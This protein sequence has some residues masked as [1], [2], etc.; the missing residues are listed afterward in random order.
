MRHTLFVTM[1]LLAACA[2]TPD[3]ESSRIPNA[4]LISI[5]Q[6]LYFGTPAGKPVRL[7]P[8]VF[9]VDTEENALVLT[10]ADDKR[11]I[12]AASS[13][14]TNELRTHPQA[15]LL[16]G[17]SGQQE[18]VLLL[19]NGAGMVAVGSTTATAP[20][21]LRRFSWSKMA[22]R[23]PKTYRKPVV[24]MAAQTPPTVAAALA[25]PVQLVKSWCAGLWFEDRPGAIPLTRA[26]SENQIRWDNARNAYVVTLRK[27]LMRSRIE[28][29]AL[30]FESDNTLYPSDEYRWDHNGQY[31]S[32]QDKRYFLSVSPRSG[33]VYE[34][35]S[36]G[37]KDGDDMKATFL[38]C[39]TSI[40]KTMTYG[41]VKGDPGP[42]LEITVRQ[43]V[44]GA[45]GFMTWKTVETFKIFVEGGMS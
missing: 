16:A 43:R 7:D 3:P 30:R 26:W 11:Q 39:H 42:E 4:A 33:W 15:V 32:E 36:R 14:T 20:R 29:F 45:N 9:R 35:Q 8:G 18:L 10:S 27:E 23:L 19:P 28:C 6:P 5:N 22:R 31:E 24:A 34:L 44:P 17:E 41:G 37:I 40:N 21:G 1:S 25:R 2:A 13:L 12:V 38:M